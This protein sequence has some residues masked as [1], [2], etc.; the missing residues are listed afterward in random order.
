MEKG[1]YLQLVSAGHDNLK[2]RWNPPP[3]IAEDLDKYEVC[4][5]CMSISSKYYFRFIN[6]INA[7]KY[8]LVIKVLVII[9][10]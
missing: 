5:Q 1:G 4:V 2:V 8:V 6:Y 10:F 3:A 7:R 9:E